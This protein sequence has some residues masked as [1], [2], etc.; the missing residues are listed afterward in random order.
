MRF[1]IHLSSGETLTLDQYNRDIVYHALK[2]HEMTAEI[3]LP[4]GTT[5]LLVIAHVVGIEAV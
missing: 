5:L 3:K 4:G 1:R 2:N